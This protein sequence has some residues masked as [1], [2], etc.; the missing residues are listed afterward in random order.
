MPDNPKD[1]GRFPFKPENVRQSYEA[2]IQERESLT[3]WFR[4]QDALLLPDSKARRLGNLAQP[5]YN[6]APANFISREASSNW[7][8]AVS[9]A[10]AL[11]VRIVVPESA[12]EALEAMGQDPEK[13]ADQAE[14]VGKIIT[15]NL[16]GTNF[17]SAGK[18]AWRYELIRGGAVLE[19]YEDWR[20]NGQ[21]T[22]GHHDLADVVLG[23]AMAVSNEY[24]EAQYMKD[25]DVVRLNSV[26][27]FIPMSVSGGYNRLKE[28]FG[29]YP[30]WSEEAAKE[31]G[32]AD[33]VGLANAGGLGPP[34]QGD[35]FA[36]NFIMGYFRVW[37]TYTTS[38]NKMAMRE[39][40]FVCG[41][42]PGCSRFVFAEQV[43]EPYFAHYSRYQNV[44][45]SNYGVGLSDEI[46][47]E[48][49]T[50]NHARAVQVEADEF[51]ARP[52]FMSERGAILNPGARRRGAGG[53][54]GLLQI[55]PGTPAHGYPRTVYEGADTSG[56]AKVMR[57]IEQDLFA[58]L[59]S[60]LYSSLSNRPPNITATE[61]LEIRR[62][63][64]A[65]TNAMTRRLIESLIRPAIAHFTRLLQMQNKLP[66]GLG[67]NEAVPLSLFASSD[68]FS[69]EW[70]T[71]A[72][73]QRR[74]ITQD[75][76]DQALTRIA[77]MLELGIL[78]PD[79]ARQKINAMEM[80]DDIFKN[81]G[82]N[83]DLTY[84]EEEQ[85]EIA[86]AQ[87][88]ARQ[89]AIAK[90]QGQAPNNSNPGSLVHPA[91]KSTF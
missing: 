43:T 78:T 72:D 70:E 13:I 34:G 61:V 14:A 8:A 45:G 86:A 21:L 69:L 63:R 62:E 81:L 64:L 71:S 51:R 55:S 89:A 67:E 31:I 66:E 58:R 18:A 23:D 27:L 54:G 90:L 11:N 83:R 36:H 38:E 24:R 65:N 16:E 5:L 4:E 42:L 50:L 35:S 41:F 79:E 28:M 60:D 80:L 49:R 22:W 91:A 3:D 37:M 76:N 77:G 29:H 10:D 56:L 20:N 1:D 59:S 25:R 74:F 46:M 48:A 52:F 82:V 75:T 57:D 68:I 15:T 12:N 85:E 47:P 19:C 40:P 88:E 53:G 6:S 17:R 33:K 39:V 7:E 87:A 9:G 84:S 44:R 73:A 32:G 26:P 2:G 30:S